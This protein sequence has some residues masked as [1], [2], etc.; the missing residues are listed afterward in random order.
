MTFQTA[1]LCDQYPDLVQVLKPS[2]QNFGGASSIQG[3]ITTIAL[4]EDNSDLVKLL[5][6]KGEKRIV[7][8]D[9]K[10]DYYAIVGDTLMGYAKEN[11]WS[12][13]IVNG[14]VRD[15][16]NTKDI[17]VGLWALGTCP[18]KSRKKA[19]SQKSITVKFLGVKFDEG[20]YLYADED[21]IVTAKENL[22]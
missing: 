19:P 22:L 12:G 21:G 7:V 14:Y 2:L 17:E 10:G 18:M 4:D 3:K 6:T 16:K 20:D 1:D 13:I 15:I 9:A 11:N 8:V 5:Q